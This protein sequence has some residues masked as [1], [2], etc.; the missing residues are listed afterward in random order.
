VDMMNIPANP[1]VAINPGE[2]W[3]FVA[4]FR[5]KNPNPTSNFTGGVLVLF[6]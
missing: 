5:D 1:P 6:Q 2:T 3:H 4:W